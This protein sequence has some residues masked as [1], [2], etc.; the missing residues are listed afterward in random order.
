MQEFESEFYIYI[1]IWETAIKFSL[2]ST[3]KEHNS[4]YEMRLSVLAS[5]CEYTYRLSF[6][7]A[8]S[9]CYHFGEYVE[10]PSSYGCQPDICM[11][12]LKI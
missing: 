2:T 9:D 11:F 6:V 12:F 8:T 7:V 10:K 3:V 4:L 1:Y 5:L